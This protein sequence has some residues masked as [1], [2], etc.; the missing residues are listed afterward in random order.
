MKRI[1]LLL[2]SGLLFCT[3]FV[4][5]KG[6]QETSLPPAGEAWPD[7]LRSVW[8][9]TEAVKRNTISGDTAQA[10]Q[11]LLEAI[12]HDSTYAPAYFLLSTDR[13]AASPDEAV[14]LAR[15]AW[16]LDTAN[17]W[18]ERNYSQSLLM[19]GAYS[20]ALA[21]YRRLVVRDANDPDNF[22]LLA[23]LY[24]MQRNPYMA[25]AT[26]DSAELR[27]GRMPYLLAVKRRL[28]VATNQ[29]DKAIDEARLS[30]A[31]SPYDPENRIVLASLYGLA[32]KDSLALAEYDAVLAIDS[33]NVAALMSLSDFYN[34]R[35]DY[36]SL[37]TINQRLFNLDEMP[38]EEKIKRFE[39]FTADSRFYREYYPQLHLLASTLVF[40]YP[41]DRRIVEIYANHLIRSGELEQALELFKLH[42]DDQP[43]QQEYYRWVIDIE[44][45]LQRPDSVDRYVDEALQ[46]FPSQA[47]FHI[48]KG[49][50][51]TYSG[52]HEQAARIYR[53]SL[54]YAENDSLRG[55]IWGLIGDAAH[56]QAEQ[57]MSEAKAAG[58]LGSPR[59][60]ARVRKSMKSC[61]DAY[62]R[63]LRFYA[64]NA[65]VLNNYAYF[66]A[67]DGQRLDRAA[68]MAGRA[69]ELSDNNPTYLDTQAWVLFRSGRAAEAKR[70][71][72]QAIALDGHNSTELLVHYG[73]ILQALG[74]YF[75]AES[76]WR[77]A[78]EK[79]YDA[80]EI[81][82]RVE[83]AQ[84][85]KAR[86]AA[87]TTQ[88]TD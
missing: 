21:R 73:D 48:A 60:Q 20:E 22:R 69:V 88:P 31:E 62:D 80:D 26:L 50:I 53:E 77:K 83:A 58:N 24:E 23:A 29:I 74:E 12:R 70:I 61:Y 59:V 56:Q 11:L 64:D 41:K 67:L 14:A 79:G 85:D 63:S 2:L 38:V 71:M 15:R 37:L 46:L 87:Q 13:L 9:Y 7:S 54:R 76:Y 84:A 86:Q 19:A 8:L 49:N 32:K 45:Y 44:S 34:D 40:R 81:A 72:Q 36:R 6:P 18:Y 75:L 4:A 57:T 1:S 35:H 28:L 55:A 30:V 33:T 52:D 65:L 43:P 47:D 68:E 42:L 39:R 10:R 3:A 5:G 16:E 17:L 66:L 82:R 51:Y 27:F 25:L 78:L